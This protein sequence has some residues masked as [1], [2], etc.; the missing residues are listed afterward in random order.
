M[1]INLTTYSTLQNTEYKIQNIE[2]RIQNYL[3]TSDKYGPARNAFDEG[4]SI[5]W[6]SGRGLSLGNPDFFVP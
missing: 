5:T 4:K 2:C 3:W 1:Y 6:A